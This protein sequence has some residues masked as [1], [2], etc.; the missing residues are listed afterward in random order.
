MYYRTFDIENCDISK[1]KHILICTRKYSSRAIYIGTIDNIN[2]EIFTLRVNRRKIF[3]KVVIN[4][5]KGFT[6][7]EPVA[8]YLT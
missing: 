3:P 4:L 5:F 1:K 2:I 6:I 7:F 8:V